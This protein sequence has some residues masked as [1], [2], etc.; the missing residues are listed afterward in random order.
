MPVGFEE[1]ETGKGSDAFGRLRRAGG[2]L[3]PL[4]YQRLSAQIGSFEQISARRA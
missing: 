1:V 3:C 2:R 4:P